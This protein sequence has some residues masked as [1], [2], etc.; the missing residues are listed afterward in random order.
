MRLLV[1]VLSVCL[2]ALSSCSFAPDLP[3]LP[4]LTDLEEPLDLR[5]EPDDEAA[6]QRLPA[7]TF[8]GLRVDD[9][10][11]TLA[12]KLDEPSALRIA[13]VI[14]NSPAAA[15][16][17]L[18]DDV[19]L[20]AQVGGGEVVTLQRP[21]EWRQLELTTPP[22]T[23]VTLFVDRAG[24]EAKAELQLVPRVAPAARE[25][26]ERYREELRVGV[27][28]RTATE[29]EARGAQLGPGGG[30]VV[31]GLSRASPWRTVGVRFGDLL[32]AIDGKPV[33]HPQDVLAALRD[34][35]GDSLRLTF[36]RGGVLFVVDAPLTSRDR[37]ITEITVP[38][39]LDYTSGRG[40]SECS[41]LLGIINYRSTAAA[42]R[43][44]LLWFLAIG[45]GDTDR[46]LE[47]DA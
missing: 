6:R 27:V 39:L 17:L 44:R 4:T 21:S 22:G 45:A 46:L 3:V 13:E 42:W 28:L 1:F 12:A 16:G 24:R 34:P 40:A 20:T 26:G 8:S 37:D 23:K 29:V 31:V 19:L 33:L 32:T 14:E 15:A 25:V 41:L 5:G 43:F 38:L 11:D 47:V 18:V 2:C 7:G 9:A 35:A 30:A 10:R 36:A